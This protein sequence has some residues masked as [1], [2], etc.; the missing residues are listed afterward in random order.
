M[1]RLTLV[2]D[3]PFFNFMDST[4][5]TR[6]IASNTDVEEDA[7]DLLKRLI[8]EDHVVVIPRGKVIDL[9]FNRKDDNDNDN[10]V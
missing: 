1:R 5:P 9:H 10:E 2:D 8:P 4:D 6:L 7:F 3:D